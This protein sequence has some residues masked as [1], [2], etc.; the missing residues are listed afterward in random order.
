MLHSVLISLQQ[1]AVFKN[2]TD[3]PNRF[4]VIYIWILNVCDY[5]VTAVELPYWLCFAHIKIKN[6]LNFL[7]FYQLVVKEIITV[8]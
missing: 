3:N 6:L 4:K 1:G 5:T 7:H 8:S 2:D